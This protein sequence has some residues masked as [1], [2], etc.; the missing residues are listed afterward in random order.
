[1]QL[2]FNNVNRQAMTESSQVIDLG[3][4]LGMQLGPE[5]DIING[6]DQVGRLNDVST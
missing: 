2:R 5:L 3:R 1:M 6:L 4:G